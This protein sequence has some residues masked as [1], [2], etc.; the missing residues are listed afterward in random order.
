[1]EVLR[2]GWDG[3]VSE[4]VEMRGESRWEG[5]NAVDR[6]ERVDGKEEKEPLGR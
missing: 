4:F 5:R 3:S 1:M 2:E 6:E